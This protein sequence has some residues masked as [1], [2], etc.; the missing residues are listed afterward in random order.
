M[1]KECLKDVFMRYGIGIEIFNII[2]I[3]VKEDDPSFLNLKDAKD[4]AAEIKIMGEKNYRLSV[5]LMYWMQQ[6][7]TKAE[8]Q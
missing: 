2:S 7:K 3:T 4:A 8:A 5:P 1:Q 6:Q